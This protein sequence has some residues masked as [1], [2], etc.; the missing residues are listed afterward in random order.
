MFFY[1]SK[2]PLCDWGPELKNLCFTAE[3]LGTRRSKHCNLDERKLPEEIRPRTR[4]SKLLFRRIQRKIN[5]WSRC[6]VLLPFPWVPGPWQASLISGLCT[7]EPF[8]RCAR[9]GAA[10][11]RPRTAWQGSVGGLEGR[12]GSLGCPATSWVCRNKLQGQSRR[13]NE[14]TKCTAGRERA[15]GGGVMP[16][17]RGMADV[18]TGGG[19]QR[20]HGTLTGTQAITGQGGPKNGK[21]KRGGEHG[22]RIKIS[23]KSKGLILPSQPK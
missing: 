17:P 15:K 16:A 7:T 21:E 13:E 23:P 19:G 9:K 6:G 20:L 2:T 8:L 22:L 10:R 1:L 4:V 5:P 14:V 18:G 3:S 11:R 12:Q